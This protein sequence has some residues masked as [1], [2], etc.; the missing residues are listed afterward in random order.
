MEQPCNYDQG[1]RWPKAVIMKPTG[2]VSYLDY[3]VAQS[4][5]D[6]IHCHTE[7]STVFTPTNQPH[8]ALL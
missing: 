2:P 7:P 3:K 5:Q 4:H 8:V 6:Q 1:H